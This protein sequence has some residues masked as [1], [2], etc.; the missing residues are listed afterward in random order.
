MKNELHS[1]VRSKMHSI[2]DEL[3]GAEAGHQVNVTFAGPHDRGELGQDLRDAI[4]V[5]ERRPAV[6]RRGH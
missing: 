1:G 5:P 2:V 3:W 6:H 4:S